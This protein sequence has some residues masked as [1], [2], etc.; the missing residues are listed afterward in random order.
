MSFC[1]FIRGHP[2]NANQTTSEQ[3]ADIAGLKS[4][5]TLRS[6]FQT[7]TNNHLTLRRLCTWAYDYITVPMKVENNRGI[8]LQE[9]PVI[10][11]REGVPS[12]PTFIHSY[13]FYFLSLSLYIYIY[14]HIYTCIL[15][16][17]I[18]QFSVYILL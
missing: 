9:L 3:Q 17:Y 10:Q 6:F 8:L 15:F 14:I 5:L 11:Q 12:A 16:K 13:M 18:C 1:N 4:V 2:I 7:F